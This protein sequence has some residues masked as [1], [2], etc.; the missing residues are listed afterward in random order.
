MRDNE[1]GKFQSLLYEKAIKDKRK[2]MVAAATNDLMASRRIP[3]LQ[4]DLTSEVLCLSIF[5]GG[6]ILG[7]NG[8]VVPRLIENISI[9]LE[10]VEVLCFEFSIGV[11]YSLYCSC[12][13]M[14]IE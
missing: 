13:I 12:K 3:K 7:A 5:L 10:L 2:N 1:T 8:A 9:E 6:K 11:R 4:G 14:V